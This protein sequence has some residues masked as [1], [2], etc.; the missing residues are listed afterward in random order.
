MKPTILVFA[1][2]CLLAQAVTE[3][4]RKVADDTFLTRQKNIYELFWH[5]DQPTVFHSDLYQKARTFS[6]DDNV[7]NYN[8]QEAVSEFVQLLKH[9]MLP[10][11]NVFTVMNPDM[12]HQA[13]VLF[14]VLFSAKT[15]N[16]FYD[17]AVWARFYL[18]EQMY[19]YAL[20]VAV[21]QR[22]D[23][24]FMKLP[25]LYE[26]LPH[27]YFNEDV[28]QKAYHIAMGNTAIG[29]KKTMSGVDYY[30]LPSNYSGWYLTRKDVPE[31]RLNYFTE[32]VGLSYFYFL[33]NHD[34]PTFMTANTVHTPQIRGEYYFFIHKQL[35]TRY[36][37]E[38]LSNG[39]GEVD[40]VNLNSPVVTGYYPTMHFHN[41]LS[42]PQRVTG[43]TVP[44]HMQKHVQM[45]KDLHSRIL[46]AIDVGY[47]L[48]T[49]GNRI[50]V[51]TNDGLNM[52]GN[53]VQGNADSL[54]RQLYG[55]LDW[56]V[57]K[58]CGFGYE[59][60]VRYQVVPSALEYY[61]TS[62]RDP[63][64][65]SM[66]QNILD[67]YHRYKENVPRY[68]TEDLSFTGVTIETVNVDELVTFFDHFE[69]MLNNG[70]SIRSHREAKNLLI[71][72]RQ[73][74]LNHKRFTYHIT[75]NSNR[76]TKGMVRIFLGPKYDE[77]GHELDLVHN[78]KNFL[79][80]DEFIVDLVTGSNEIE[81]NSHESVFVV[82]DEISSDVFYKKILSSI[83]NPHSFTY[84]TKPY[85]FPERLLLPR[86]TKEGMVYNLFVTISPVTETNTVQIDSPVWGQLVNDGRAMGF[87]LD[88]PINPLLVNTLSNMYMKNVFIHHRNAEELN[89]YSL[90]SYDSVTNETSST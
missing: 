2:F 83:K 11:G 37:L 41:G 45:I 8:D 22:P 1:S 86:G 26:V 50:K 24:K 54:N 74:R 90:P 62:L 12:E 84:S 46:S 3:Q 81:R 16:V 77:F 43:T 60:N 34:F 31:Q 70:L 27:L 71:R 68:T 79:Q 17:T 65:Y 87:P 30:T 52:L 78:Y 6:I 32:D 35:L 58:V 39:L 21:I 15:F 40:R 73:Y 82:P 72:T 19:L 9:G 66:Y 49:H 4:T 42:F 33:I 20:S 88:R 7:N 14:R 89:T 10:R 57:R 69:S 13:M 28:M 53:L 63:I 64:F 85:G 75:V 38:R 76:N 44:L 67:Y 47:F 18:N 51:Y 55:R 61:S 56:L 80:M 5:V 25:P 29:T 36:Y 23:T 48:D 59:S